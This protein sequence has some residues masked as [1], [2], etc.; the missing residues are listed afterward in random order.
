MTMPFRRDER[1]PALGGV[2]QAAVD[3]AQQAVAAVGQRLP[4]RRRVAWYARPWGRGLLIAAAG[5]AL[6]ALAALIMRPRLNATPAAI[7]DPTTRGLASTRT[8]SYDAHRAEADG[9]VDTVQQAAKES[10]PASDAPVWGHG[11]DLP[12]I[13]EGEHKETLPYRPA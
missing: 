7:D 13:R 1:F 6:A 8:E 11:P 10:F 12:V 9:G 4:G 2:K 5:A 3:Q